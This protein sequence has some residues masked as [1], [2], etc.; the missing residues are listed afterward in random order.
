MVLKQF[1]VSGKLSVPEF[2]SILLPKM[3]PGSRRKWVRVC[4]M[5]CFSEH[6]HYRRSA[7]TERETQTN[8]EVRL[9]CFVQD[10]CFTSWS[11]LF[12]LLSVLLLVFPP[13][14]CLF[15][16]L[17]SCLIF[18]CPRCYSLCAS[19]QSPLLPPFL[20]SSHLY[21]AAS[22]LVYLMS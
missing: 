9:G 19:F 14:P 10:Y 17:L 16:P 11:V 5:P 7:E 22:I 15:I 6:G 18:F 12:L 4:A 2:Q 20:L 1:C 3:R 13:L 8:R 21:S